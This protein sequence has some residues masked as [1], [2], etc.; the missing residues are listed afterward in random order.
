MILT[1][2]LGPLMERGLRQSLEMSQG[3]MSILIERPLSAA[4]L[5]IAA[6][7]IVSSVFRAFTAVKGDSE[8]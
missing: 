7:V 4:L 3:D 2:V 8:V 1:F 6:V 5:A